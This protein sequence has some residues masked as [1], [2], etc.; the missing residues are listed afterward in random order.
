MS[1]SL[2]YTLSLPHANMHN[3]RNIQ[4][5]NDDNNKREREENQNKKKIK[6]QNFKRTNDEG[7][8]H[9]QTNYQKKTYTHTHI[10]E[11][12]E[13]QNTNTPFSEWHFEQQNKKRVREKK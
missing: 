6:K 8:K 11:K 1:F 13:K 3:K 9:I 2:T 5:K 4:K 12:E 10:P 7:G